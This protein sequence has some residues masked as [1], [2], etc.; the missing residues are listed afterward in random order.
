MNRAKD[1]TI[2]VLIIAVVYLL[3]TRDWGNDAE[4]VQESPT[5]SIAVLPFAN[6]TGDPY[7]EYFSDDMSLEILN[8]LARI[9]GLK[10]IART[11]SFAYKGTNK[12]IRTVG[13]ALGASYILEG[14]IRKEGTGV[15]VWVQLIRV[16][17]DLHLWSETYERSGDAVESIP[18]EIASA[19]TSVI[20]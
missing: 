14:A 8:L 12:D 6:M 5:P 16:V 1:I 9:P 17:D 18:V 11:S 19:I 15:R 3:G 10:V 7:N 20:G 4:E 13:A 2:V